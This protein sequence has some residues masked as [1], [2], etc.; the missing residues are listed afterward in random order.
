MKTFLLC[1]RLIE[2]DF[3]GITESFFAHDEAEFN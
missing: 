1:G 2:R 3:R